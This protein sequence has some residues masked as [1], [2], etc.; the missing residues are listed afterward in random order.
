MPDNESLHG[1]VA[2]VL[3]AFDLGPAS[4][5]RRLGGTATPKFAV[6]IPEGRFVVRARP[7]EFAAEP[8]IRFDHES[9]SRLAEHG[10]PVPRPRCRP[11]GTSWLH[12]EHGV[13]EVLSWIEGEAFREGDRAAIA[14]L[15]GFLARFHLALHQDIPPGKEGLLREDHPDLLDVYVKQLRDLCRTPDDIP[16]IDRLAQQLELVRRFL[17]QDLY[18][19]LPQAVIHGD[20][21]PGNVKFKG[22]AV[23]AV[24][25]FDYL[26]QQARCRDLVDALMFFAASRRQRVDPNDI[27]S[28]TQPFI[29]NSEWSSL[30]LNGYQRVSRLSELEWSA[31][32]WLIRSQWL[33][34]RLRGSRKVRS[35]E[36]LAFVL[37]R[38]F[39][40]T[41]WLDHEAPDFFG[42]LR[43]EL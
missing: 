26:S 9:L 22:A 20:I 42:E 24:Y 7:A 29:F 12:T 27:R 4:E 10:L 25:D 8:L 36:K 23:A 34:I 18:P 15:G 31:L 11:D 32:P 17:D 3:R 41:D 30:L 39:E 28:L 6:R 1:C 14:A 38:F 33:Q 2:H 35:E 43:T 37:D 16:Q 21:H 5:I 40:V 13:F 19:K